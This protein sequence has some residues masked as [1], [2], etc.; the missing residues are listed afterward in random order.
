M[1]GLDLSV[2]ITK[3]AADGGTLK[4]CSDTI[5]ENIGYI[6]DMLAK[7]W[8]SWLGEDSDAYVNSLK[9]MLSNLSKF[10]QEVHHVGEYMV[11]LSEKYSDAIET[12]EKGV[13][14]DE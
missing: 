14:S 11:G 6:Q 3:L 4:S 1:N 8:Y 2:N 13:S 10:S 5:D 12:F 9:L 7:E